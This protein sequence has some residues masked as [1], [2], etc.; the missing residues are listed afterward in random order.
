M[1]VTKSA[2]AT[3]AN[4][5]PERGCFGGPIQRNQF[6]MKFIDIINRIFNPP[7]N[8]ERRRTLI[9][10]SIDEFLSTVWAT[11]D[12]DRKSVYI[13]RGKASVLAGIVGSECGKGERD[14]SDLSLIYV[15]IDKKIRNCVQLNEAFLDPC[16]VGELKTEAVD[17]MRIR[18]KKDTN[19]QAVELKK[20]VIC[21][22]GV[23][24]T[25]K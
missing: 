1:S 8:P 9:C 14:I 22:D 21:H 10:R 2:R 4:Q 16:T 19:T 12:H 17:C 6:K 3:S 25:T 7:F 5:K 18:F 15:D 23:Y 20:V 24:L 11:S 13:Y